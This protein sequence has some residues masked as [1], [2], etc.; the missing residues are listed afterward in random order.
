MMLVPQ[1]IAY[2][3]G[4][5][6]L[7]AQFGLYSSFMGLFVYAIFGT[8]RDLSVGPTAIIS[9]LIAESAGSVNGTTSYQD[10]IFLNFFAGLIQFLMGVFRLGVLVEFLSE[11]VV[12]GFISG[13]ALT[14][15]S[16]QLKKLFGLSFT[17]SAKQ[18]F[19]HYMEDWGTHVTH[20]K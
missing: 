9:L 12:S 10:A 16:S 18:D 11:P 20:N 17:S 13:A 1:A 4:I 5:A 14:I 3:S 15:A 8:C 19:L 6:H 7:P 2:A